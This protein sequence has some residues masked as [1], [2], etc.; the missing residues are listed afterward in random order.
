MAAMVAVAPEGA[1]RTG[2]LTGSWAGTV[3]GAGAKDGEGIAVGAGDGIGVMIEV[4]TGDGVGNG[5][6]ADEGTAVGV[7]VAVCGGN[8]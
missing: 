5:D 1:G 4:G 6:V 7:G 8:M 3:V 2:M